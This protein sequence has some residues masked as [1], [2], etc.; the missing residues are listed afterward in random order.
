MSELVIKKR[1]RK[2]RTEEIQSKPW[3]FKSG[4]SG[5]PGGRPKM[6]VSEK[7]LRKLKGKEWSEAIAKVLDMSRHEQLQFIRD[8][9]TNTIDSKKYTVLQVK[10]IELM[11]KCK[12]F[13]DLD[14][15]MSR[16]IGRSISRSEI[17]MQ[18]EMTI[19]DKRKT[20][21]HLLNNINTVR[22]AYQDELENR[23]IN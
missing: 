16:V 3:L 12:S 20:D 2:L 11:A 5:N 17:D 13:K 1:K 15:I 21:K 14:I 23:Q 10:I 22:D 6:D 19:Q 9:K 4:Q 7:A 8:M 18:Q